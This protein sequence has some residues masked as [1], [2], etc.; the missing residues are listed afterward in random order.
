MLRGVR[1]TCDTTWCDKT[2]QL[3]ER[4]A[5][6]TNIDPGSE[7]ER[8]HMSA[9]RQIPVALDDWQPSGNGRW[10]INIYST[11]RI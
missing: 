1:G 6:V 5:S 7:I 10:I 8:M 2:Q 9:K 3:M 11:K 4:P